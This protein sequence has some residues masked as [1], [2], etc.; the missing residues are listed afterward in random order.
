M[1]NIVKLLWEDFQDRVKADPIDK[2]VFFAGAQSMLQALVPLIKK[3]DRN[4]IL[5]LIQEM[6]R[7]IIEDTKTTY[8][9]PDGLKH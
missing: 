6:S 7:E 4:Q 2:M 8:Q 1:P 5:A 9:G 3:H